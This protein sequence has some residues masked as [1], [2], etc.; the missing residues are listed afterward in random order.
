MG[1]T[2]IILRLE[3]VVYDA[4]EFAPLSGITFELAWGEDLVVFGP[5]D[6]GL[7][8][9]CPLIA[10]LALPAA[11]EVYF[12][13]API[14]GFDYF[15]MHRY[16]KE[17]GYLQR[18]YGLISNMSAEQNI[19]L[20]LQYHSTLSS[21]ETRAVADRLIDALNLEG[22]RARR[23]INL[24]M[25]ETLRTA[26]ARSLILEPDLLL[27]EHALEGQCLINSQTF[28]R[29]LERWADRPGCSL[30]MTTYEPDRF[31]VCADRFMMLYDGRIVFEGTRE[32]YL[33]TDNPYVRQYKL[34]SVDGP[35]RIL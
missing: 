15:Q 9:L 8:T 18:D 1:T 35:M 10:G 33:H 11:G 25:S 20:P 6:S 2:D 28:L 34:A 12:K 17:L 16:R 26:F 5:E 13:G 14:K 29:E 30:M 23:P 31:L 3:N 22:C 4:D 7:N 19:R 32:E 24:T 27:V 21:A